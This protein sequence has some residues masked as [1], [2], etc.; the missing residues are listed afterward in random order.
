MTLLDEINPDA[1]SPRDALELIYK[2]K[3]LTE[4]PIAALR[5]A[6]RRAAI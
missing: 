2:L 1:L 3:E 4:W 6:A 5:R